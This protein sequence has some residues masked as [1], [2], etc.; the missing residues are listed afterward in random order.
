MKFRVQFKTT[1]V[2]GP[3]NTL[4]KIRNFLWG[5]TDATW[6]THLIDWHTVCMNKKKGGLG[7]RSAMASNNATLFKLWVEPHKKQT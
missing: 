4:N 3:F 5:D 6:K 2:N 1:N 7:I